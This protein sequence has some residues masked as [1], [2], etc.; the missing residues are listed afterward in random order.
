[1]KKI[2][3]YPPNSLILTDLVERFGHKPLNLNIV[4]GKLVRT[5]E[6]DSPPMNITDEEPKKGLKYAA[7]EVPSGVRGRMALIGPLIDEAEAAIIMD[8]APLA[9]GCIGCQRTNEL[10]LYLVKR[11]NIPTLKV[12]YPSNEEEAELLVNKIAN[13]LKSLEEGNQ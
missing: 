8:E 7:V 4:I 1:M 3:I 6:I 12:K 5:P 10:T 9:F 13:F 11:K 2:F